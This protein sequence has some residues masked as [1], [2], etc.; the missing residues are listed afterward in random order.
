MQIRTT[1]RMRLEPGGGVIMLAAFL[2][3]NY[4]VDKV[5]FDYERMQL[6]QERDEDKSQ[7]AVNFEC[8]VGLNED[9]LKAEVRITCQLL[10]GGGDDSSQTKEPF[11]LVSIAGYFGNNGSLSEE[12]FKRMC[13]KNGIATL[14]PFLRAAVADI[15][16]IANVGEPVIL[17]LVNVTRISDEN[18]KPI[19][20]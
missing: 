4:R 13:E 5:A 16:R 10:D 7:V 8:A 2:F 15:T 14:F 17:P 1:R 6:L 11:L 20:E 18:S 9:K 3:N 12:Q 19:I